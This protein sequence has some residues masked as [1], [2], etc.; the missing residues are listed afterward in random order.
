M[1][2]AFILSALACP[3][4]AGGLAVPSGQVVALIEVLPEAQSDGLWLRLRFLAPQIADDGVGFD[5][6][7][8]DMLHLCRSVGLPLLKNDYPDTVRIMVSLS[9]TRLEFGVSDP[10]VTQYFEAYQPLNDDC[11]WEDF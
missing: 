7:S 11:I 10:G 9:D 1:R 6:A 2:A 3:A 8:G 4:Q 5:A